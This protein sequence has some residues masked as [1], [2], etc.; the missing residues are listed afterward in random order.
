VTQTTSKIGN[1]SPVTYDWLSSLDN[2]HNS[3]QV[4]LRSL[5]HSRKKQHMFVNLQIYAKGCPVTAAPTKS[6]TKSPTVACTVQCS[7]ASNGLLRVSHDTTSGHS[8]H[9][10]YKDPADAKKCKCECEM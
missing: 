3:L 9:R 4:R 1:A 8:T 2:H 10:C 5:A 6:P 7:I